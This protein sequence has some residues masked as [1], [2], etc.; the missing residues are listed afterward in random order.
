MI[1]WIK[2]LIEKITQIIEIILNKIPDKI[3]I[4][5]SINGKNLS[6]NSVKKL[7]Q[8]KKKESSSCELENSDIY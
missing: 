3:K 5:I 7:F 4:D 1:K 6:K 8:N 2:S